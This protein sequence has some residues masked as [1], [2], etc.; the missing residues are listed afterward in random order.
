MA[1]STMNLITVEKCNATFKRT[2]TYVCVGVLWGG[3]FTPQ[4]IPFFLN[5][6]MHNSL[7]CLRNEKK[8]LRVSGKQLNSITYF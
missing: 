8:T 3:S 7:G 4:F 1:E 5:G 6:M 2:G